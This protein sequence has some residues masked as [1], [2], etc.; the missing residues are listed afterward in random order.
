MASVIDWLVLG[1][2]GEQHHGGQLLSGRFPIAVIEGGESG[3]TKA[4]WLAEWNLI[5]CRRRGL[6]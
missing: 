3:T 6:L 2:A 1:F 5:T 4:V